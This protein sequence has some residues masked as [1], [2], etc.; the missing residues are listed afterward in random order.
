MA[1]RV[2]MGQDAMCPLCKS[3]D[4]RKEVLRSFRKLW[5]DVFRE[6]KCCLYLGSAFCSYFNMTFRGQLQD[7]VWSCTWGAWI[8]WGWWQGGMLCWSADVF[9]HSQPGDARGHRGAQWVMHRVGGPRP[10]AQTFLWATI[11]GYHK[12]SDFTFLFRNSPRSC[13]PIADAHP[14]AN[15]LLLQHEGCEAV[16]LLLNCN[17]IPQEMSAAVFINTAASSC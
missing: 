13:S 7:T 15:L 2:R 9:L 11:F 17:Q 16:L 1:L 3:L 4:E 5:V 12:Q 8:A 6:S 10:A 14:T